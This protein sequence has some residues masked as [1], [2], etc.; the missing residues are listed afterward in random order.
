MRTA[1]VVQSF[2]LIILASLARAE[3][4]DFW[5]CYPIPDGTHDISLQIISEEE[6]S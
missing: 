3:F 1:L 6:V 5:F 4:T 2:I